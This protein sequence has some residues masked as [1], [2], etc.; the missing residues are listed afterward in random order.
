MPSRNSRQAN[1]DIPI[2][3]FSINAVAKHLSIHRSTVE[4]L[5]HGGEFG[6][7]WWRIGR[8]IIIPKENV[9]AYERR[10][11]EQHQQGTIAA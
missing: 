4:R 10:K 5:L 1:Q 6:E 2:G 7:D 11:R 8:R 3:N 9:F